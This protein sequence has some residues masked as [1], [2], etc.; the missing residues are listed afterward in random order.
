MEKGGSRSSE[1]ETEKEIS[2]KMKSALELLVR[3]VSVLS[4]LRLFFP[5]VKATEL[6]RK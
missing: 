4:P 1:E 5:S 6:G 2:R 3:L